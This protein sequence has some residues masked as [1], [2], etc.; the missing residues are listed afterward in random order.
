MGPVKFALS[1]LDVYLFLT[2]TDQ[3]FEIYYKAHS[4][5]DIIFFMLLHTAVP[6]V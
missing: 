3:M 2:R 6:Y 5:F 4:Y 1:T